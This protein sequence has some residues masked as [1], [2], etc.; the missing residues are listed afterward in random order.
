MFVY[1][2]EVL[3]AIYSQCTVREAFVSLISG[4]VLHPDNG[5][6]VR[7]RIV[8]IPQSLNSHV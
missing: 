5:I 6:H 2:D 7:L 3:V 1:M 4:T 8:G